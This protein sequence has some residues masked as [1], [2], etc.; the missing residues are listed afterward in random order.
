MLS[1]QNIVASAGLAFKWISFSGLELQV[2]LSFICLLHLFH[3]II[4]LLQFGV[5]LCLGVTVFQADAIYLFIYLFI[6]YRYDVN[7][8]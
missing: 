1:I 2:L 7:W 3:Q 5:Q 6:S 4:S 8:T